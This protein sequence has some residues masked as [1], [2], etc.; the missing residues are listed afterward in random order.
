MQR[1]AS[2]VC[3][4]GMLLRSGVPLLYLLALR[5][6]FTWVTLTVAACRQ[7]S[8]M[9]HGH[10]TRGQ[11]EDE[12]QLDNIG[13]EHGEG[14][15]REKMKDSTEEECEL[16]RPRPACRIFYTE[17]M[18][19][20]SRVSARTVAEVDIIS[21][22]YMHPFRQVCKLSSAQQQS[23]VSIECCETRFSL[24]FSRDSG[25]AR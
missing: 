7:E 11:E 10:L 24:S 4:A 5:H 18:A 1:S 2:G 17:S 9:Y 8:G 19:S 23:V 6:V 13:G 14:K 22:G 15:R 3:K 20:A 21:D 25:G 12:G 16:Y